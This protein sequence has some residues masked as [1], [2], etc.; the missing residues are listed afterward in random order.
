[1]NTKKILLITLIAV[2]ILASVSVVSAGFLE[3]LFGGGQQDKVIELDGITFNTTNATDFKENKTFSKVNSDEYFKSRSY[4]SDNGTGNYS[5]LVMDYSDSIGVESDVDAQIGEIMREMVG[6]QPYQTVNGVIVYM[7]HQVSGKDVG[8]MTYVSYVQNTDLHKAVV[9][10]S[11]DANETAKM[12]S[13]L[14]FK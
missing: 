1:M 4:G 2:A 8:K 6:N 5:V 11:P 14:K 9:F 10:A 12:A 7:G 3:D 13:T